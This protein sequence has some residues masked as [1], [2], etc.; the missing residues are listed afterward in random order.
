MKRILAI[1]LL[2]SFATLFSMQSFAQQSPEYYLK[3]GISLIS[4]QKYQE[5]YD[6]FDKAYKLDSKDP[7]ILAFRGQAL[8]YLKRY[9]EA[10][11]NYDAALQIQPDYAEVYHLR[12]MAR[13]EMKDATGACEDW[14]QANKLGYDMVI[15]L[16][17]EYCMKNKTEK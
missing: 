13:Y 10:I 12:G 5:A 8:H 4:K 7:N 16:I 3:N 14:E 11:E 6:E 1:L 17:I 9:P 15:D 2:F